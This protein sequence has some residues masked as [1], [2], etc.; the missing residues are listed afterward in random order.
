MNL[1]VTQFY[2]RQWIKRHKYCEDGQ[3]KEHYAGKL[4]LFIKMDS[5]QEL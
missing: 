3:F 4:K 1:R 5:M 2:E